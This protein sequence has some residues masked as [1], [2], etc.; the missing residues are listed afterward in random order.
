MAKNTDVSTLPSLL[1]S[2]N[3]AA[4]WLF[5]RILAA[6]MEVVAEPFLAR[7]KVTTRKTSDRVYFSFLLYEIINSS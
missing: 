4:G 2:L 7:N 3:T 1:F 5:C 6:A